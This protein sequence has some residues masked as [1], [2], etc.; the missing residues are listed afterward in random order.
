M[1]FTLMAL[2]ALN[3]KIIGNQKKTESRIF[4]LAEE[5]SEWLNP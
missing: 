2:I 1:K 5:I 3:I 4:F